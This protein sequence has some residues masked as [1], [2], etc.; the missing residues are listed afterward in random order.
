MVTIIV[1]EGKSPFKG[2]KRDQ[3]FSKRGPKSDQ[4]FLKKGPP[5]EKLISEG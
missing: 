3:F 4:H 5:A 2:P 1:P